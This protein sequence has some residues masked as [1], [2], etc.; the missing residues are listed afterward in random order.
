MVAQGLQGAE[1]IVV[2]TDAQTLAMSKAPRLIQLR[3]H[4]TEGLAP[5]RFRMSAARRR[6]NPSTKLRTIL[7]VRTIWLSRNRKESAP[8]PLQIWIKRMN[9]ETRKIVEQAEQQ[10]MERRV[11]FFGTRC[12]RQL[13][14]GSSTVL[15]R[16]K[17]AAYLGGNVPSTLTIPMSVALST[18]SATV[19]LASWRAPGPLLGILGTNT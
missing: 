17:S 2:N 11:S 19:P 8:A 4:V 10:R 18:I 7:A 6:K 14:S 15:A 16:S 3:A 12:A 5:D 1:F 13:C 9:G